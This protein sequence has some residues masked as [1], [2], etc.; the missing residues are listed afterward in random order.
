M[1]CWK[2]ASRTFNGFPR[3]GKTPKRSR[4]TMLR[5]AT[6]KALALSPSVRMRV[7]SSEPFPPAQLA[8]SSLGTPVIRSERPVPFTF[9]FM[10]MDSLAFAHCNT[11]ST[12]PVLSTF[13]IAPSETSHLEPNLPAL[14]VMVSLVCESKVGFTIKQFTNTQMCERTWKGLIVIPPLFF[15]F[16]RLW[17]ASTNW[18]ATWDTCVPPLEV[19]MQFTKETC[20]NCPSEIATTYS[21]RSPARS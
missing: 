15:V 20:W 2:E 16:A 12:I 14:R 19:L 7:H 10:S 5:P 3:S 4:P 21:Q 13:L 8:S 1:V 18:S 6:A 9:F 17:M 11:M